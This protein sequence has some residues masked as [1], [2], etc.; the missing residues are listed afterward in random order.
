M[1]RKE[2]FFKDTVM[3]VLGSVLFSISVNMF[4]VP[5]NFVQGGLTG[6]SVMLNAF[7]SFIPIGTGIFIMNIPLLTA[8]FIKL[9]KK[10]VIKTAAA[11]LV[12]TSIIDIGGL[13]IPAY[14][15]DSFLA[16]LFCGAFS[17]TGLSLILLSGATT[18]GTEIVA[19]LLRHKNKNLPIGRLILFI[20]LFVI[21]VSFFY[22][23]S[24]EALMYAAV[25]LFVAVKVIDFVLGGAGRN[26][27]MIIVTSQPKDI[28]RCI[29]ESI[30]RGVTV[31]D[32]KGGFTEEKKSLVFCV[33]RAAEI[34]VVNRR[35]SEIDK[36]SFT[37]TGDVG[38]V[39]GNGF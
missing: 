36:N 2:R 17:G 37:V 12:S 38:E 29:M 26:K 35:L 6:I 4:S 19:M 15:G 30:N 25:S 1:N 22:Y 33:A 23:R 20:D 27:M 18:G 39:F 9:G 14:K 11:I 5:N 28:S 3:I 13:F 21:S 31:M 32:V 16:S 7:L 10:F 34:T 8:A 24:I